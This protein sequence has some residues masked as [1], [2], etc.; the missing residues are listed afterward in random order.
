MIFIGTSGWSYPHWNKVFYPEDLA[1]SK[2]LRFFTEHFPTVEIN[3]T[4]YRF[5]SEKA[6]LKWHSVPP[7]GFVFAIKAN[8]YITH[9]KRLKEPEKTAKDF[10]QRIDLLKEKLGPILFQLPPSFK[11]DR[12]RLEAFIKVLPRKHLYV[13]EFRHSSWDDEEIYSLLRKNNIAYCISDLNRVLSPLVVTADFVYIRLHGPTA[14]YK[15]SYSKKELGIWE[16]RI[17][18]W[19]KNKI[20]T[21]C[22]FDN[23]EKGFAIKDAERLLKVFE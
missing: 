9:I 14:S 3:N 21:Y 11:K 16:K 23:D 22:Y 18:D 5:P 8:R 1:E 4:F 7:S 12:E 10:L 2:H 17:K 19:A 15:G 13:F 6:L 20:S